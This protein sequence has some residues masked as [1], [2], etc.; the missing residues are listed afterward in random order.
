MACDFAFPYETLDVFRL[1]VDVARWVR[2]APWPRGHAHLRDQAIR[3]SESIVLNIAEGSGRR[4]DAGANH[5]RIAHGSAAEVNAVLY[6]VDLPGAP[7][8]QQRLRR[9]GAMLHKLG[10]QA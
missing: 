6:L 2:A 3:A 9:I 5:H 8:A 1:A 4:G 10:R 7:D